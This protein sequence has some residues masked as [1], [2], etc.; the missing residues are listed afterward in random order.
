MYPARVAGKT[1]GV[2]SLGEARRGSRDALSQRDAPPLSARLRAL[3]ENALGVNA[4]DRDDPRLAVDVPALQGDPLLGAQTR[5]EANRQWDRSEAPTSA[6][7]LDLV[8]RCEWPDLRR[9]GLAIPSVGFRSTILPLDRLA[10]D[11]LQ[12]AE[13]PWRAPSEREARQAA[14]SAGTSW[15]IRTSPNARTAW[16]RS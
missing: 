9:F 13:N 7:S 8:P 4:L 5:P 14:I 15:S 11:L 12:R 3:L 10:K 2:S 16:R 6:A 1:R